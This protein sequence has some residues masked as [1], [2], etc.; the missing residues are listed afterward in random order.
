MKTFLPST[1]PLVLVSNVQLLLELLHLG[2]LLLLARRRLALGGLRGGSRTRRLVLLGALHHTCNHISSAQNGPNTLSSGSALGGRIR[3][4]SFVA[5]ALLG[6]SVR[7]VACLRQRFGEVLRLACAGVARTY[8]LC[9][10]ARCHVG[11]GG[12]GL[13]LVRGRDARLV[14]KAGEAGSLGAVGARGGVDNLGVGGGGG[15][16]FGLG[17]SG[18]EVLGLA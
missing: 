7:R 3:T 14:T 1:S 11:H 10:G 16:S 5:L 13:R 6:R 8:S 9:L 15:G 4:L 18:G 2:H 17:E 12:G